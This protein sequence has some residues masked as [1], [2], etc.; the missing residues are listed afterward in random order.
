MNIVLS[1]KIIK[2]YYY[3]FDILGDI[4]HFSEGHIKH[5]ENHKFDSSTLVVSGFYVLFSKLSIVCLYDYILY[6]VT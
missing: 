5:V 2:N 3:I 4:I 1:Y 6:S